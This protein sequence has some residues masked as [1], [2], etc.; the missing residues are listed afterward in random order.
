MKC[1]R[2]EEPPEQKIEQLSQKRKVPVLALATDAASP[3]LS[4]AVT[5]V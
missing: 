1:S 5:R 3:S 4:P 2:A